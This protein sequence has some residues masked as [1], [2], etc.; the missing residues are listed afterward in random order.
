MATKLILKLSTL[1]LCL[2]NLAAY[3]VATWLLNGP[4]QYINKNATTLSLLLFNVEAPQRPHV[5]RKVMDGN[6]LRA[7]AYTDFCFGLSFVCEN[8]SSSLPST[9]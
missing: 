8:P 2:Y 3:Y 6:R 4:Q 1:A 5:N 9:T 7:K